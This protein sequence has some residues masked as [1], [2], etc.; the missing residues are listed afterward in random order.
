M[1][2][3]TRFSAL[4][5]V[6]ALI[7]AA[8]GDSSVDDAA[9]DT[10]DSS[11]SDSSGSDSESDESGDSGE[12]DADGDAMEDSDGDEDADADAPATESAPIIRPDFG[13]APDVPDEYDPALTGAFNEM[14]TEEA[15]TS[16]T[17]ALDQRENLDVIAASGDP[18]AAWLI[19]DLLRFMNPAG[20]DGALLAAAEGS[21]GIDIDDFNPW[22]GLLDHLIAWDTPAPPDYLTHKRTLFSAVADAW[23][24][25]FDDNAT[26]LVDY[27]HWS[28]GGVRIDDRAYDQ[29]DQQCNCIP[30]ADNPDV[31]DVAG[32][33]W[34]DDDRVVF[35]VEINGETRAYPRN[36]MEIREMVNDTLGGRDFAMPYCTLCGSA[37]V[38][39]TDEVPDGVERPILRTSGLLSRSNK[40]M[41]DVRTQSVFDT[42]LGIAVTG[43]LAEQGIELEQAAVVTTTWGEWKQAHPDTT[44]LDESLA[45]GRDSDLLNTRDAD[46]PIFPIGDVDPR[47][48]V[49]EPVLGVIAESGTPVAFPV[50]AARS[51]LLDGETVEFENITIDLASGGI[52]AID[53]DGNELGSHQ[54]FWFAWSQFHGD[55]EVWGI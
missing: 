49:Q 50:E 10:S 35:G 8:C 40:V 7:A 37:Q 47:L 43:P 33:D 3:L 38:F 27:R 39:F 32:G 26:D 2:L 9:P 31:T 46:G 51:R 24:P 30:A 13:P 11:G 29:T 16:S 5:V 53:A 36:I 44:I 28:W 19:G 41:Y 54:A 25:F 18:R 4:L 21:T 52:R 15:L 1:R 55:T 14:F 34:Y 20:A 6:L 48:A 17:F 22:G 45:L 12:G 42:F 23:T